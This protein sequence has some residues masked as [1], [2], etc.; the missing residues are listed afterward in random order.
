MPKHHYLKPFNLAI[1]SS[2]AVS[3]CASMLHAQEPAVPSGKVSDG[4][5]PKE[6]AKSSNA[7]S[8]LK[9]INETT[10]QLGKIIIDKKKRTISFEAEAE[11]T[12]E[13]V[14]L[15]IVTP[16]GRI[17]ESLFITDARPIHLNIAFKLLGY[18]ENKSL[19]RVFVNDIPTDVYQTATEEEKTKSYFT[20]T[21]SWIDEK[22]KK[23]QSYNINELIKNAETKEAVS[24]ENPK[25]SYGGSFL[26]K[27][28]FA[29]EINEDLIA[30]YTDRGAVANFAGKGREDDTLWY[31]V[32]EKM[33]A[34]GTKV[35]ITLTPDFPL[36]NKK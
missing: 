9:K 24:K 17:H 10:Y 20:T 21:V 6:T 23:K 18:K 1:I 29:A 15:A 12:S 8:K 34:K 32:E 7:L 36:D 25:W 3:V 28:V 5:E 22:T 30:I 13:L 19:Y 35:T 27:G 11:I 33:P 16:E 31:P 14:E 26:H 4:A 2:L